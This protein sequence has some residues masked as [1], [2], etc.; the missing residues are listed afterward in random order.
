MMGGMPSPRSGV[1]MRFDSPCSP[2]AGE[3]ATRRDDA[4]WQQSQCHLLTFINMARRN[5]RREIPA[6]GRNTCWGSHLAHDLNRA[7][8]ADQD[9]ARPLQCSWGIPAF[10]RLL[11][12]TFVVRPVFISLRLTVENRFVRACSTA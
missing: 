3:H 1:G 11:P 5:I 7:Q 8:R 9:S 2:A 10:A 6:R 12:P 4:N